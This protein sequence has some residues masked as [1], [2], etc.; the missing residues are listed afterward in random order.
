MAHAPAHEPPPPDPDGHGTENPE[1]DP[2]AWLRFRRHMHIWWPHSTFFEL[3]PPPATQP[4]V[5]AERV[6]DRLAA[7]E[8]SAP[9]DHAAA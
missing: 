9:T 7:K 8:A 6:I 3:H 1:Q 2:A 4:V 5:K